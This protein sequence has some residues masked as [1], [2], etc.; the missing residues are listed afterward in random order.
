MDRSDPSIHSSITFAR[1]TFHAATAGLDSTSYSQIR[2]EYQ[3]D[4][5]RREKE[6]KTQDVLAILSVKVV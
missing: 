2:L 6:K 3:T 4:L 5:T 1:S